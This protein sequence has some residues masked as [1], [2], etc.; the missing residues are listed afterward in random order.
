MNVLQNFFSAL[1]KPFKTE[2][3]FALVGP[4]G[5]GK[6]YKAKFIANHYGLHAIIDDG[7][8]IQQDK[9]LAGKSAK[10]EQN[11][12]GAVRVALFDEEAHKNAVVKNIYR[13]HIKRILILGT[14]EK[15]VRKIAKRLELPQPEK[16]IHIE[17]ISSKE[18][19]QMAQ[20]SRLIEGKH[21][22][23]VAANEVKKLDP[24]IFAAGIRFRFHRFNP[25]HIFVKENKVIEKSIV[26]PEFSKQERSAISEAALIYYARHAILKSEAHS[27]VK[28]MRVTKSERGYKLTITI[29]LMY[30]KTNV[31]FVKRVENLQ[32]KIIDT[33]ESAS[34][35]FIEEANIIID[36]MLPMSA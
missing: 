6:S 2:T 33:I 20:K 35:I 29:S 31:P 26:E 10:S 36:K 25:L 17:D 12:L 24:K 21:V 16:I 23:P 27:I 30:Q 32:K 5:T 9:I 34:G 14:S 22:I 15:M 18:E 19:I 8:L 1:W 13:H 3:V 4:S 11:F 28:K 7:L